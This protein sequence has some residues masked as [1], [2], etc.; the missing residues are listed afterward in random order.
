MESWLVPT[1]SSL[2]RNQNTV[3]FHGLKSVLESGETPFFVVL[4]LLE[5]E[6]KSQLVK[7]QKQSRTDGVSYLQV[8]EQKYERKKLIFPEIITNLTISQKAV[9]QEMQQNESTLAR[10]QGKP[11]LVGQ[12]FQLRHLRSQKYLSM[13]G[14]KV[15]LSSHMSLNTRFRI[16]QTDEEEVGFLKLVVEI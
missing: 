4:P 2:S 13:K 1:T 11:L 15:G 14:E 8:M 7:K 16:V 6:I 10:F 3:T 5:Y 12:C 9:L